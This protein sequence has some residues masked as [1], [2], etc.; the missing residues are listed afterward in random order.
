[1]ERKTFGGRTTKVLGR[2]IEGKIRYL[3]SAAIRTERKR[4][5]R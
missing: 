3:Y 1:M 5:R 4:T 2:K